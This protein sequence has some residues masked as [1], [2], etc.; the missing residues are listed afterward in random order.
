MG[1]V[2]SLRI[3]LVSELLPDLHGG[4]L[5]HVLALCESF[6]AEG[7]DVT[8][9]GRAGIAPEGMPDGASYQPLL[10]HG[11]RGWKERKVGVI[12]MD[13][14]RPAGARIRRVI[15][16]LMRTN[17]I[18]HYHGHNV[19]AVQGLPPRVFVTSH[20]YAGICPKKTLFSEGGVCTTVD[21]RACAPCYL[22]RR[23]SAP[24]QSLSAWQVRRWRL[25]ADRVSRRPTSLFV[26]EAQRDL[27]RNFVP[28]D[29]PDHSVVV[30]N[31]LRVGHVDSQPRS[32]IRA[33][34][35][36]S[37]SARVVLVAST[38]QDYKGAAE[39]LSAMACVQSDVVVVVAGG[40]PVTACESVRAVGWLDRADLLPLM[41]SADLFCVP[42]LWPE[43][44]PTTVYE[45][46]QS[47]TPVIALRRGGLPEMERRSSG[48]VVL[49]DTVAELAVVA[50]EAGLRGRPPDPPTP[51]FFQRQ[52]PEVLVS[53]Y[54]DA[55]RDAGQRGAS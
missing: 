51:A 18:V 46:V 41:K 7:H 50:R 5:N 30:P 48:W 40:H 3:A 11:E 43:P 20:D 1:S 42:S 10:P 29:R 28:E 4:L 23:V 21:P 35:G 38:D 47:G 8:L 33:K 54:R 52:T 32:A 39:F 55:L 45:A 53:L 22:G 34:Y 31:F 13:R 12:I 25:T 15:R 49:T 24:Q 17:D 2:M 37:A 19:A 9:V 44:C 14:R 6:L 36:L 27:W 16:Q 26:S